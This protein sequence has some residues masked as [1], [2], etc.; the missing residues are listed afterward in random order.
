MG[1]AVLPG[2]ESEKQ[3]WKERTG[4]CR[5][6][7]GLAFFLRERGVMVLD[8]R[9]YGSTDFRKIKQA[10]LCMMEEELEEH[11]RRAEMRAKVSVEEVDGWERELRC[12]LSLQVLVVGLGEGHKLLLPK[13]VLRST[14]KRF[15]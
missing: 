7:T 14:G 9:R 10:A 2:A 5:Y 1:P 12:V 6:R 8:K 13:D 15:Q 3:G 4:V 11:F